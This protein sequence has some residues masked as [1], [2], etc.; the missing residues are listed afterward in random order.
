[1]H[2]FFIAT[3]KIE[4][5]YLS[6]GRIICR[7]NDENRNILGILLAGQRAQVFGRV[8]FRLSKTKLSVFCLFV[9]GGKK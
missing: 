1:M 2:L 7:R 4:V 3:I 6:G 8:K 9:E 5:Q